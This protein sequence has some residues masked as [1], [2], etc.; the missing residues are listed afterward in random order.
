MKLGWLAT[1][2]LCAALAGPALAD[3]SLRMADGSSISGRADSYDSEAQIVH[4]TTDDG[5]KMEIPIADLDQRE[6]WRLGRSRVPKDDGSRQLQFANYTRDIGLYAHSVR[7][8]QYALEADPSLKP[9]VDR[10]VEIL[11]ARAATW[12][13]GKANEAIAKGDS[14]GAERWLTKIIQK[15]PET[16]EAAQAKEM[17][18]GHYDKVRTER[19]AELEAKEAEMFAKDLS[20]AKKS[21]ES[22]LDHNKSALQATSNS[23]AK[24]DWNRAVSEGNRALNELDKWEKK[25][26]D[27]AET[28]AQYREVVEGQIIEV[29]LN[30]ASMYT[31]Q[32]SYQQA[33]REVNKALA[34]DPASN[35]ALSAR[36]RIEEAS[37]RGIW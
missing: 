18:E 30:V 5:V 3:D 22:M 12:A 1:A 17:L 28:F 33:L 23:Q 19:T 24:R 29:Y 21:Y 8:Y 35:A 9:E 32:S 13:M 2:A 20:R 15:V 36:S 4:F 11:K 34:I 26:S 14:H 25:Y 10:E 31:T 27:R 6:A 37:S 16:P 7:H